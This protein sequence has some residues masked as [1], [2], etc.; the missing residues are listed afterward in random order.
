MT[1]SSSKPLSDSEA[2]WV[3]LC[4]TCDHGVVGGQPCPDCGGTGYKKQEFSGRSEKDM[5]DER[6]EF[7]KWWVSGPHTKNALD[8]LTVDIIEREYLGGKPRYNSRRTQDA[9]DA[10]RAGCESQRRESN[11]AL[12]SNKEKKG[13]MPNVSRQPDHQPQEQSAITGGPTEP[14]D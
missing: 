1:D 2:L 6:R 4:G 11:A 8:W 7:E 3:N 12:D 5:M 10:F 9:F 13:V 14:V